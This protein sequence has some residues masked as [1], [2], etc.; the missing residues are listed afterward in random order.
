MRRVWD[1]EGLFQS[2]I[3][4][5]DKEIQV[6]IIDAE[7]GPNGWTENGFLGAILRLWKSWRK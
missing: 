3:R 2:L 4:Q 5:S 1:R 6:T 7:N